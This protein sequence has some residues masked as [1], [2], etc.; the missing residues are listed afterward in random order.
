MSYLPPDADI[1]EGDRVLT[2]GVGSVYP[3]GLLI[4]TVESVGFDPNTRET[5]A[6]ISLA[7]VSDDVKKVMIIKDFK[8][9]TTE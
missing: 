1:K 2:S 8:I 5:T 4:G 6:R 3:Q 7:S 9:T